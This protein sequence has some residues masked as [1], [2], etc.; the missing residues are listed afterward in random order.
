MARSASGEGAQVAFC[1]RRQSSPSEAR[2]VATTVRFSGCSG[3]LVER[4]LASASVESAAWAAPMVAS[5]WFA[6]TAVGGVMAALRSRLAM[7]VSRGARSERTDIV[8]VGGQVPV[9]DSS[10]CLSGAGE[11]PLI[12][13][14]SAP[15]CTAKNVLIDLYHITLHTRHNQHVTNINVAMLPL[16]PLP[17]GVKYDELEGLRKAAWDAK[18]KDERFMRDINRLKSMEKEYQKLQSVQDELEKL[19]PKISELGAELQ[20]RE[21]VHALEQIRE[22]NYELLTTW[23]VVKDREDYRNNLLNLPIFIAVRPKGLPSSEPDTFIPLE[24][25]FEQKLAGINL[26]YDK[27]FKRIDVGMEDFC[28]HP[29]PDELHGY[30]QC[31]NSFNGWND[32]FEKSFRFVYRLPSGRYKTLF[33]PGAYRKLPTTWGE[34]VVVDS[35]EPVVELYPQQLPEEVTV[36]NW[37]NRILRRGDPVPWDRW[38]ELSNIYSGKGGVAKRPYMTPV[39]WMT[40]GPEERLDLGYGEIIDVETLKNIGL[41]YYAMPFVVLEALVDNFEGS[42]DGAFNH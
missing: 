14:W 5:T 31:E 20:E 15:R 27:S 3:W 6:G 37:R 41:A 42:M 33:Q 23:Q 36:P 16:L 22:N 28:H 29:D 24:F 19:A 39:F 21:P 8:S 2:M 11:G 4:V 35:G 34:P 7:P 9:V 18:V 30:K 32:R 12:S 40:E 13:P 1:L 26:Q 25:D 17:T 10:S 38:M